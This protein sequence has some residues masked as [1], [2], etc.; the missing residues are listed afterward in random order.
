MRAPPGLEGS[1]SDRIALVREAFCACDTDRD[2]Y[3]SLWEMYTFAKQTGFDGNDQMWVEEYELLCSENQRSSDQGI[4]VDLFTHL[5][6]DTSDAGCYCSD[7]DLKA[8]ISRAA[9]PPRR[10]LAKDIRDDS[11]CV[12]ERPEDIQKGIP[13]RRATLLNEAFHACD[14]DRDGLLSVWEM[15]AFAEYAGF[16]GSAIEWENE[17]KTLC[18]ENHRS[19]EQGIDLELFIQLVEDT[20]DGGCHCRD[21]DLEAVI[22]SGTAISPTMTQATPDTTPGA[23]TPV[24]DREALIHAAFRALDGDQD[25]FLS[26]WEMHAFSKHIGFD[27]SN[28]D[29]EDEYKILCCEQ[30]IDPARGI[31]VKLF[32]KLVN[33][34]SDQGCFC[35]DEELRTLI[36]SLFSDVR[37]RL[38]VR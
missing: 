38:L 5:V 3:L 7:E 11:A 32:A 20:S 31:D 2:Q 24:M 27:G 34:Q 18:A 1:Q 12:V 26:L 29:W 13:P 17:Y 16:C 19:I 4:D 33:D 36:K 9:V 10:E 14:T 30:Q 22:S 25:G 8:I 6:N 15:H 23:A 21:E 37:G 35:S 28:E